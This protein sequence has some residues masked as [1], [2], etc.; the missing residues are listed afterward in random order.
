[1][2]RPL[3]TAVVLL[4]ALAGCPDKPAAGSAPALAA[5][6]A[7]AVAPTPPRPPG[8]PAD[9]SCQAAADCEAV[10][11]AC[12]CSGPPS[13]VMRREDAVNRAD[14]DRWYKEHGCKRS[15]GACPDLACPPARVDCL[16]GACQIVYG[17]SSAGRASP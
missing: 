14:A 8:S 11:C 3:L 15:D 10:G 7:A 17:P 1:M 13:G 12:A 9:R 5:P 4:A 2:T 16:G 6:D